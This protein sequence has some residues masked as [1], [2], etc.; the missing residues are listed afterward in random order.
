[1]RIV[2]IYDAVYPFIKG[3]VERR[4]YEIG[5]RLAKKHD[6]YWFGL[7]WG[8]GSPDGIEFY[9]VGRWK[10]LYKN[11]K[12]SIGEAIYFA[13]KLLLKFKGKYD[14]VDCQ[15]FPYFPCFSAKFHSMIRDIPLVITWH[16]VWN[17]YWKEYLGNLAIFGLQVERKMSKITEN[18]ISVSR[19]T[20]RRLYS[21]GVH[22]EVIP[23][24]IDFKR[25]QNVSKK[26]EEYD[27]IFVGRLIRE[28]NVDLLLKAVRMVREDIPDLKVLIIGEGP[29]KERLVK[30]A[31]ILD[32]SDNVKFLGFLKDH[33]EVISYLKSSKVFVLPSKR[34][35]FG[36]VVLEA[37]ASGLPVITLDYPMNASKELIIHGYN[38]FVSSPTPDHLAKYIEISLSNRKKFRRN[39]TKNAR[40]YDWNIIAK[41]TEKFYERVLS[42]R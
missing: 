33:D 1:M 39:C 34:E 9:G 31:S 4:V 40:R 18:N 5:K 14:I 22:S 25:I 29:E 13:L 30:L 41:L 16:E 38:G 6:V 28:K 21:I 20:Q 24:G 32:L 23:N 26:D 11:G 3:G 2:Y 36:I 7:N 15:Q 19:L 42:K 12:R 17:E 37:N 35:G 10:N 8:E 27:I